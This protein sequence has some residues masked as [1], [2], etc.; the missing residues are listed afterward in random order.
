MQSHISALSACVQSCLSPLRSDGTRVHT[1][2]LYDVGCTVI[3]SK[4]WRSPAFSIQWISFQ[5][6]VFSYNILH[7]NTQASVF[8]DWVRQRIFP[9]AYI[10]HSLVQPSVFPFNC[11]KATMVAFK[12]FS[13]AN[14]LLGAVTATPEIFYS[15]C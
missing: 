11:L 10:S 15:S 2:A 5:A 3:K 1:S 14:S 8:L 4:H 12:A 7:L 9:Y 13:C 6:W